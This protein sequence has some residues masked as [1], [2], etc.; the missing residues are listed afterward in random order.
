MDKGRILESWKEIADHLGRNVRTC[1]LWERELGLPVHRLDGS[2]R[3]RVF[4]YPDELDRWLERTSSER[5]PGRERRG[6]EQARRGT[7]AR[8]GLPTLPPWNIGLIAGL[9]VL[10]AAATAV[11]AFLVVR[12]SRL[13]WADNIALPEIERLVLT[14]D[15]ERAYEL[16]LRVERIAPSSPRLAQLMP[17]VAGRLTIETD[18]PG[19]EAFIRPYDDPEAP[20]R[21]WGRTPVMD[22]R[23]SVGP[24]HWR[25]VQAGF[26]ETEGSINI[27]AGEAELIRVRLDEAGRVPPGMV[28]V[29]GGICALSQFQVRSVP[30]LALG[31]FWIDRYEVTNREYRVFVEAGGYGDRRYWEQPF[32]RDGEALGWEEAMRDFVDR[33]GRPGPATWDQGACPAGTE[34]YPVTGVSW[35]EAAAYAA[36]AGKR[37][38]SAYHWNLAAGLLREVDY[39]V[40]SSNLGGQ[41]LVPCGASGGPGPF[42]AYD[43]AGNAKEWCS[44]EAGG[45]RVNLGGA[46]NEAQYWFFL[47]DHY[48][49]FMRAGNFGFRCMKDAGEGGAVESAHAPLEIRPEPD[50]AAM[51][52]CPDPVFEAY[53]AL[54]AYTRTDLAARVESWREWS[55]DTVVEKVSFLDAGGGARIVAYLFLPRN[56]SPPFQSVVYVPGS[57]SMSLDSVFDYATV[58]SREV[59]LFTK[60]GR[61]F[62]FPVLWNTFERREKSL[63]PRSREFLRDRMVRHHREL[64]RTLDYLETRPDFDPER[65]A[66]QGLS[67]GAYAG[68]IHV[69]LERRFSAAVFVGGGFYWEMYA[70]DRGSPEWDAVNFAPRVGVPVLMQHGRYD[71]FYPLDT[72]ARL[73]FRLLGTPEGQKHLIV[74]PTGHSVWLLNEY[75]RDMLGFLDRYLGQPGPTGIQPVK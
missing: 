25:I 18:P 52:P 1:Q 32:V 53:R 57:S 72:N 27:P 29:P 55:P 47:F 62:V 61:A 11:A 44:N 75:R 38:P 3:A 37:L 33:S 40:P 23:L 41:A 74:Y 50:Y 19:A 17:L 9:A 26:A 8:T 64:A 22:R 36:F 20:W 13:R 70:P 67:W 49:P 2:P 24:K 6:A 45:G 56:A 66:Y 58:K 14:P 15:K 16:A 31:A 48:P 30:P 35:Y 60:G 51:R 7:E 63:P 68:P 73:L 54:Y 21:L 12:Q 65:I 69:A 10:A 28:R 5:E 4:A 42:G 46:W 34:D 59:E 71:A 43:M 39:M